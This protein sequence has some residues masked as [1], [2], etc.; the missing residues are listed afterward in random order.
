[1]NQLLADSNYEFPNPP[2]STLFRLIT[3]VVYRVERVDYLGREF[4]ITRLS[5]EGEDHA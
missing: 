3:G 2:F 1:M 4:K 5:L